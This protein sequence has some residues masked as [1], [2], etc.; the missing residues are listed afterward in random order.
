MGPL[1][2]SPN[3]PATGSG[4][5]SSPGTLMGTLGRSPNPPATGSGERSSPAPTRSMGARSVIA[6][7]GLDGS[8]KSRFAAAL[9]AEL[10]ADGRPVSLLHVDDFRRPTDFAGLTADAEAALYYD[11][12]FDFAAVGDELAARGRG[13]ADGLVTILEG[14]MLL[15]VALP[16]GTPLIVLEVGAAEARGRILARDEAKGRTPVEIAGRSDRRYFPAQA[17]YRAACDPLGRADLVVDNEDW[18]RPRVVRRSDGRFLP[19]VAA[20]L[21]RLLQ[22]E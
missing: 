1:G 19:G 21:D 18:R 3:P 15:R 5:R 14:V 8:G 9:A 10:Q 16:P 4:E 11:S 2:G 20:A 12:Y 22:A 6:V 13:A 17:R 7:D